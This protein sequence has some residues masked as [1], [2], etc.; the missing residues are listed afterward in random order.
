MKRERR[1]WSKTDDGDVSAE[2]PAAL[3]GERSERKTKRFE[4][5]EARGAC[6]RFTRRRRRVGAVRR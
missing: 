2:G 4:W 6:R 5:A 1:S 3:Q